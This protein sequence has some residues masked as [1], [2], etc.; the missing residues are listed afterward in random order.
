MFEMLAKYLKLDPDEL[1][2]N[3]TNSFAMVKETSAR[4]TRIEAKLDVLVS[5]SGFDLEQLNKDLTP[6]AP[7]PVELIPPTVN[8]VGR[9]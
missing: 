3:L 8:E 1:K 5:A 4:M 9:A 2:A 7:K 6:E